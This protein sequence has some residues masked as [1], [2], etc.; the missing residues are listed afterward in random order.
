MEKKLLT[1]QK[2]ALFYFIYFA[3]IDLLHLFLFTFQSSYQL[4]LIY[5]S[6]I[7]LPYSPCFHLQICHVFYF[8]SFCFSTIVLVYESTDQ[9]LFS[10]YS[11]LDGCYIKIDF[12]VKSLISSF[13]LVGLQLM[14]LCHIFVY[15]IQILDFGGLLNAFCGS[16][17]ARFLHD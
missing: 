12:L 9:Y 6:N 15:M 8:F 11:K 1:L 13:Y 4:K 10:T 3:N 2:L 17:N 7:F 16:S 5:G 14:T